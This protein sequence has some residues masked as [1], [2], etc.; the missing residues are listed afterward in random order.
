MLLCRIERIVVNQALIHCRNNPNTVQ[1]C[2]RED[3]VIFTFWMDISSMLL[4]RTVHIWVYQAL[5]HYRIICNTVTVRSPAMFTFTMHAFNNILEIL[6]LLCTKVLIL[7]L[8]Y[9]ALQLPYLVKSFIHYIRLLY[10]NLY[11]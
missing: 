1:V 3:S 10:L 5:I 7:A 8:N 2:A 4:C 9:I 11:S 6:H